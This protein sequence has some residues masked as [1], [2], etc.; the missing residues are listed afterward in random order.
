MVTNKSNCWSAIYDISQVLLVIEG[1]LNEG[2]MDNFQQI[3]VCGRYQ[4]INDQFVKVCE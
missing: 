2:C 3:H 4:N 1:Q